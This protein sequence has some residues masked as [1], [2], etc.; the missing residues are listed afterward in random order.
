VITSADH[1]EFVSRKETG[2][3]ETAFSAGSLAAM[4]A[5]L[6]VYVSGTF[7]IAEA[8]GIKRPLQALLFVPIILMASYYL[9]ARPR[10][11][12]DPLIGF[13]LLKTLAE[14]ALRGSALDMFDDI[15][16]LFA[17]MVIR[18]ASGPAI[19]QGVRLVTVLA[20]VFA[21]MAIVQW[22]IL[23]FEPDL[24]DEL[25]TLDEE[26]KVIG[27]VHHVI[28]LLGLATGELYTLFGHTV[29]RLQSFAK[30]PSLN[31]VY[32]LIPSTMAFLRGGRSG[33]LWGI[34]MLGFCVLSLSGSVLL[35]LAFAAVAWVGIRII[36]VRWVVA[37]GPLIVLAIYLTA[38]QSGSL[39]AVVSFITVL[40]DYGD[41]LS[42]EQ[43][44]TYRAGGAASSLAAVA[45]APLG[46]TKLPELPAPWMVNGALA[47]GWLGALMLLLFV[48]RLAVQLQIFSVNHGRDR[49]VRIGTLLLIGTLATVIIFN[50]YQMSNY[51]GLILL[52]MAYR[53]IETQNEIDSNGRARKS[54]LQRAPQESAEVGEHSARAV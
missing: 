50:D 29:S 34:L 46:S 31:L 20:G 3:T 47:A 30:E 8:L 49:G 53:M 14:V 24:L 12:I 4:A 48:R 45:G 35:S 6:L 22:I 21:V 37:W 52:A 43:S 10:Q 18:G 7:V 39:R 42:K 11:L 33:V 27:T 36:S 9:A 13:V 28:A 1:D 44:F 5:A 32:F 2:A 17:L 41:F 54:R 25:L 51:P 16:S 38:L 40:S 26:G 19:V 23:F 15:A